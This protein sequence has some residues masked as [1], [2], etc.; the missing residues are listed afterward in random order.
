M[1]AKATVNQLMKVCPFV[2]PIIEADKQLLR[3]FCEI[4]AAR[5]PLGHG[6]AFSWA[7][8]TQA[9]HGRTSHGYNLGLKYYDPSKQILI[10]I[11]YFGRPF[12]NRATWHFHV[13]RPMGNW[14]GQYF[15]DLCDFLASLSKEVVY[16]KKITG[17]EEMAL[18]NHSGFE[19]I[20]D[21]PWHPEA[22]LEDDTIGEVIL[23]VRHTLAHRFGHGD[24]EIRRKWRIFNRDFVGKIRWLRYDPKVHYADAEY[25]VRR[26]MEYHQVQAL[27]LSTYEDYLN[28]IESLPAGEEGNDYFARL[29]YLDDKPAGLYI[30]ERQGRTQAV[31]VYANVSLRNDFRYVSE[32]LLLK[33]LEDVAEAGI[34]IVNLGGSETAKL[35]GFKEKFMRGGGAINPMRWACY[36][37]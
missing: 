22:H 7:Y 26:F 34:T 20:E 16:V 25:V 15:F 8:V 14:L 28:M 19:A 32:Y 33:L 30:V 6:Y 10:P 12:T 21:W 27:E 1:D 23:D 9:V 17:E 4:E 3:H 24:N 2:T 37:R 35:H 18:F 5:L 36:R 11:G 13:V 31:G 29:L